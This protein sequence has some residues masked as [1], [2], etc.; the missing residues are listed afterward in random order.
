VRA[1]CCR[2]VQARAFHA[3]AARQFDFGKFSDAVTSNE[4]RCVP[5]QLPPCGAVPACVAGRSGVRACVRAWGMIVVCL[6]LEV[7]S[8]RGMYFDMKTKQ[9]NEAKKSASVHCCASCMC[10][11]VCVYIYIYIYYMYACMYVCMYVYKK[12]ASVHCCARTS[13]SSKACTTLCAQMRG[14]CVCVCVCV[15]GWVDI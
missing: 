12:S 5:C 10:V 14:D 6:S 7:D 8:L 1:A 11:C 4:A 3:S 9:A 15:G 13:S 2:A